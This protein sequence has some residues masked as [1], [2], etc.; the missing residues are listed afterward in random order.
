MGGLV[1]GL[2]SISTVDVTLLVGWFFGQTI[3]LGIAGAVV[4]SGLAGK[5]LTRL[6]AKVLTFFLLLVIIT[7]VLQTS[8]LASASH[9]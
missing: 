7:I 3:E 1:F 2:S 8:G 4:G 6:F 5:P 9:M